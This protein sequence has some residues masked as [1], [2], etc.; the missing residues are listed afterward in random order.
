M[1]GISGAPL[2]VGGDVRGIV[3]QAYMS[4]DAQGRVRVED[5][6]LRV[7]TLGSLVS[8]VGDRLRWDDYAELPFE[9][10][11][12]EAVNGLFKDPARLSELGKNLRVNVSVVRRELLPGRIARGALRKGLEPTYEALR[13]TPGL[14]PKEGAR[15]I[16][17]VAAGGLLESPVLEV[18]A[19]LRREQAELAV[20]LSVSLPR[21]A[22]FFVWRARYGVAELGAFARRMFT[23]GPCP[24]EDEV[25][26]FR[27]ELRKGLERVTGRQGEK[28]EQWI[29]S[30]ELFFTLVGGIVRPEVLEEVAPDFGGGRFVQFTKDPPRDA[31]PRVRAV[32][33][34]LSTDDEYKIEDRCHYAEDDLADGA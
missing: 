1:N 21:T 30:G 7:R 6:K 10:Q 11:I 27:S 13:N 19:G 4:A 8:A 3:Q 18:R 22:Q 9:P 2:V 14:N 17:Y 16:E 23:I 25:T 32:T 31:Q 12:Q 34:G 29:E 33:P 5:S 15:I 28:L 26:Y 20:L 24:D